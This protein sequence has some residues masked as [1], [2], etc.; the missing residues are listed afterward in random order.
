MPEVCYAIMG[1]ADFGGLNC[2]TL[3][4]K[5]D[6]NFVPM[7]NVSSMR[8]LCGQTVLDGG[9]TALELACQHKLE[10]VACAILGRQDFDKV[11]NISPGN[12][13][14]LMHAINNDLP[15]ACLAILDRKDFTAV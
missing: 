1:R 4:Q 7:K 15:R 10:D 12:W 13:T 8:K 2:I 6:P 11:N 3:C 14:C 5:K 9:I